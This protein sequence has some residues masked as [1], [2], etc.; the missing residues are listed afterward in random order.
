MQY[1]VYFSIAGIPATGLTPTWESLL[2]ATNATD[3]SGSAPAITEIGS[4]MYSFDINYE[5]APWDVATEELV[6]VIDGGAT[7]ADVD[8]YKPVIIT[9]RSL[10]LVRLSH[11]GVYNKDAKTIT[12][13]DVDGST[14]A[15]VQTMTDAAASQT[16][17]LTAP[18][19]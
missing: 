2:T 17:D 18:S 16:R 11:K 13:Y 5:V 7:L 1:F 9:R 4:G 14:A 15:L 3:K 12:Y 10:A 19:S 8:R 6:G